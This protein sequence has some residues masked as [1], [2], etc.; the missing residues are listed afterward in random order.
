MRTL[1][2]VLYTIFFSAFLYPVIT[3]WAWSPNGWLYKM[4]NSKKKKKLIIN[5]AKIRFP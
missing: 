5:F 4:G 1:G 3:H 2:I